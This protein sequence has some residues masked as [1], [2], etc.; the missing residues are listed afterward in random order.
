MKLLVL[1]IKAISLMA[2]AMVSGGCDRITGSGIPQALNTDALL[3][4]AGK[5]NGI[6]FIGSGMCESVSTYAVDS[7]RD[8]P[9]TI[10]SGAPGRL[11]AAYRGE[12]KRQIETLG[13]KIH[14]T[15]FSGGSET[16]LRAFSYRYSWERNEGIV[17][18][19]SFVGT[20]RHMEIT[21]FCYEHRR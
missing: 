4:T 15:G 9:I 13:G 11:L 7:N 8:F 14:D 21:L 12:V 18:V 19:R 10:S 17:R 1:M 20:N 16:D 3:A 5:T 2:I 6:T